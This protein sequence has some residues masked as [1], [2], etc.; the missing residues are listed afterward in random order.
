[1]HIIFAC[2]LSSPKF[3]H[4]SSLPLKFMTS[5]SLIISITCVHTQIHKAAGSFAHVF[6]IDNH[7]KL[8]SLLG[9]LEKTGSMFPS[10]SCL[11]LAPHLVLGFILWQVS[12]LLW[13]ICLSVMHLWFIQSWCYDF[14]GEAFQEH[15]E[16]NIFYQLSRDF[17]ISFMMFADI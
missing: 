17:C 5:S 8:E 13:H 11:P 7:L 3:P 16:D 15:T 1:M 9:N 14:M 4:G 10:F 6:T 2:F 12:D